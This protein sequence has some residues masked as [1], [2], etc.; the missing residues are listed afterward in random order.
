MT[1]IGLVGVGIMGGPMARKFIEAG[2]AVVATD[3]SSAALEKVREL[4]AAT[5][6]SPAAVARAALVIL[7]SLPNAAIVEACLTG[8][9][10]LLAGASPGTIIANTSTIDPQSTRR[11]AKLAAE[12]D[13]VFMDTPILGRPDAAGAWGMPVGGEAA[14]LET[15]RPV[16]SVIAG[17]IFHAGGL[18]AGNVV[19]LLNNLM[20]GAINAMTAEMMAIAERLGVAPATLYEIMVQSNGGAVSNLFR[21]LG[22]RISN[23]NYDNPAFSVR[24]L[25]KD[26]ALGLAMAEEGGIPSMIGNAVDYLNRMAL[27][28]G[29]GE[30]DTSVMWKSVARSMR[31]S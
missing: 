20:F 24:L 6:E 3:V 22:K 17:H 13:V 23:E 10:G 14:H 28:Q 4:G 29:L 7:L 5:A 16:L 11:L 31:R 18:G 30:K 19:K 15:L 27:S 21:E 26:I 8:P 2:Y 25:T 9:T 12:K 1:T